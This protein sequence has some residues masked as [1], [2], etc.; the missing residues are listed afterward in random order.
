MMNGMNNLIDTK[1]LGKPATW[2]GDEERWEEWSF[3]M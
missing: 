1:T 3:Q 2:G